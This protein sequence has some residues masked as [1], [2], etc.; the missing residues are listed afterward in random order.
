M[1]SSSGYL[2]HLRTFWQ[3]KK[4]RVDKTSEVGGDSVELYLCCYSLGALLFGCSGR[5]SHPVLSE[6]HVQIVA[7]RGSEVVSG[8][9]YIVT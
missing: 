9:R 5:S 3:F 8:V 2:D 1:F 4:L 6:Y 7:C